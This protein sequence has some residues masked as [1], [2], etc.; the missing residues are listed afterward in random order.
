MTDIGFA[1]TRRRVLALHRDGDYAA[2]MGVARSAIGEFPDHADQTTYWIACLH[3]LLD[4]HDAGDG[5]RAGDARVAK[6]LG[7]A[8]ADRLDGSAGAGAKAAFFTS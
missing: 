3:A 1:A 6:A 2:A 7:A 8:G 5:P 4:D